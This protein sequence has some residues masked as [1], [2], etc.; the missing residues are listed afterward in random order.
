MNILVLQLKRIGDLVLTTP[1]LAEVRRRFPD[2]H[3]TV[4]VAE[5]CQSLLPT[6]IGVNQT[7]VFERGSLNAALWKFVL[8]GQFELSLDF[9]GNDRSAL[10]T[11][12]SRARQRIGF[13]WMK[14]SGFRALAYN[15]LIDSPVSQNHTVDHYL[16]LLRELP[17]P[18]GKESK[19]L[20]LRL[21][22]QVQ[23]AAIRLAEIQKFVVIHPGTARVE[24]YWMAE[25]WVEV[26]EH[27][28]NQHGL[29][30]VITG[31]SDPYELAHI[32]QI[33]QALEKPCIDLSGNRDLLS[34][35][36]VIASAYACVRCDT[37]A[38]HL[39][40]AFAKPQIA[41]YGV[42]NPFHWRPRH[43]HALVISAACPDSPLR[44]F[45]PK[46][47]GA[48][49]SAISTQL[50]IHATDALFAPLSQS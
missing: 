17:A 48:P 45:V 6:L 49:M 47:K 9:T 41:L 26:I 10:L 14:K 36:A 34:F 46:M 25:R 20:A 42:T 29:K 31:G 32:A 7:L 13:V 43:E 18:P 27:I 38:V 22:E 37:A 1:A 30:C 19:A 4:I 8:Q 23:N 39:A 44:E 16:E 2:A 21:P 11:W 3:I 50:V 5:G 33:Q 35:A 24:K 15:R 40:A 28:R 12:C